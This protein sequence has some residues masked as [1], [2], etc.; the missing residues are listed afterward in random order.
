VENLYDVALYDDSLYDQTGSTDYNLSLPGYQYGKHLYGEEL[1]GDPDDYNLAATAAGNTVCLA[2]THTTA[3]STNKA[4][5]KKIG[6][7]KSVSGNTVFLGARVVLTASGNKAALRRTNIVSATSNTVALKTVNKTRN[8]TGNT[9]ALKSINKVITVAPNKVALI[10]RNRTASVTGNKVAL[11]AVKTISVILNT[12]ALKTVNRSASSSG[13]TVHLKS[14]GVTRSIGVTAYLKKLNNQ[15]TI[16]ATASL[17]SS[18]VPSTVR[19]KGNTVALRGYTVLTEITQ[20]VGV[21]VEAQPL[22]TSIVEFNM[23]GLGAVTS[24]EAVDLYAT[25]ITEAV[26]N[27][28]EALIEELGVMAHEALYDTQLYDVPMYDETEAVLL[29]EQQTATCGIQALNPVIAT[30]TEGD[31]WALSSIV[32]G[33]TFIDFMYGVMMY[34][35]ALYG[36]TKT[37]IIDTSITEVQR[38]TATIGSV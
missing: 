26:T 13:N 31:T 14:I 10:T 21:L 15:R 19:A 24:L 7:T 36:E 5:L 22:E 12:A 8:A 33:T 30:I 37:D 27:A 6:I 34:G 25:T 18:I 38:P 20:P 11:R 23:L 16:G 1:Y 17:F 3:A 35:E 2:V 32:S 4:A 28:H 29:H 9:A